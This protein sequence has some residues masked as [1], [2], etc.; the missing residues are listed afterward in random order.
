[1]LFE[2]Y[3]TRSQKENI[4]H[5]QLEMLLLINGIQDIYIFFGKWGNE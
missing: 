3:Q 5:F 4:L 1:M 2:I